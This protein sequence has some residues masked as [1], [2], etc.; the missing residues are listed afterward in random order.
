MSEEDCCIH[1]KMT[2]FHSNMRGI[3]VLSFKLIFPAKNV[4]GF[5]VETLWVAES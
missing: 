1:K 4:G 3:V 2:L 5:S